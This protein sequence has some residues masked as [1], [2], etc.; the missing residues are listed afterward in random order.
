MVISEY[1]G[2][3]ALSKQTQYNQLQLNEASGHP[4]ALIQLLFQQ[5]D[6]EE[7]TRHLQL[8]MEHIITS[9]PTKLKQTQSIILCICQQECFSELT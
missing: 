8:D 5:P 6:S 7:P 2:L 9:L 1:H 3:L 4:G